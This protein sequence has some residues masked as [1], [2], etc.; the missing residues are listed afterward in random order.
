MPGI[1]SFIELV[2]CKTFPKHCLNANIMAITTSQAAGGAML[3]SSPS[4]LLGTLYP[5]PT[6]LHTGSTHARLSLHT[7]LP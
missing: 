5:H 6:C 2:V 3:G 7:N 1:W 4:G